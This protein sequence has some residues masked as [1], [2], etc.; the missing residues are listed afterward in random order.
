MIGSE[1]KCVQC[2]GRY[3]QPSKDGMPLFDIFCSYSCGVKYYEHRDMM[4]GVVIR[5][6]RK[7][8][9]LINKIK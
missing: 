8:G 6:S 3:Y 2:G 7:L 9:K 1:F 5:R 4:R